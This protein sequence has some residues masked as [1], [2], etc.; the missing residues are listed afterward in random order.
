[1][2]RNRIRSA[3]TLQI[4]RLWKLFALGFVVTVFGLVFVFFQIRII[5]SADEIKKL[6][7]GLE[8]VKRKNQGLIVQIEHGKSPAALQKQ[9]VLFRLGMVEMNHPNIRVYDAPVPARHAESM[10]ARSPQRP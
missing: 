2:A 1:M 4:T 3:N 8:E 10:M 9:I 7:S 6:E 5:K